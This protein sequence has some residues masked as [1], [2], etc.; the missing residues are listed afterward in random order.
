M[1]I[2]FESKRLLNEVTMEQAEARLLSR[3]FGRALQV[4]L[5]HWKDEFENLQD[6]RTSVEGYIKETVPSDISEGYKPEALWWCISDFIKAMAENSKSAEDYFSFIDDVR[7][8]LETFFQIKEAGKASILSEKD[9]NKIKSSKELSEV[10]IQAKP[11][12]DAY[13]K[14]KT[15]KDAEAGTNVIYEDG[16]WTVIIPENKG[17]ACEIGRDTDWCTRSPGLPYYEKTHSKEDPLI[18]F[19]SKEDPVK[20]YQFHYGTSQFMDKENQSIRTGASQRFYELNDIVK[21]LS[22]KLPEKVIDLANKYRIE[23]RSD[24]GTITFNPENTT[25]RNKNTQL[26]RLDGPAIEYSDGTKEWH[27]NDQLH[28]TD[29]PAIE[30][31][32]GTKKWYQ[33][34]KRHRTDGPAVEYPNGTKEWHQNN[35]LHR[36]DGPAIEWADGAKDWYQNGNLHRLDGPALEYSNGTKYWFQNGKTHRTDGPAVEHADGSKYWYI[37]GRQFKEDEFNKK[38]QNLKELFARYL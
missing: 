36:T 27:Q 29:G 14:L 16:D 11:A 31:V 22:D 13:N 34:G 25:Y 15:S 17:A 30:F 28:R 3:G 26:H 19:I 37:E 4:Y 21:G 23:Q 10:V 32:N 1:K 7:E 5:E 24:G 38:T 20:R 12:W 35:Q 18:I 9:I 2:I 8:T 33:N 6:V